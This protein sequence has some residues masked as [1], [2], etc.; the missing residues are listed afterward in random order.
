MRTRGPPATTGAEPGRGLVVAVRRLR[1]REAVALTALG[2]GSA[3]VAACEEGTMAKEDGQAKE[4]PAM[5]AILKKA[6]KR[7]LGG[8]LPGFV[9]MIIQVRAVPPCNMSAWLSGC[10]STLRGPDDVA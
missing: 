10:M 7:A 6:G 8:G 1:L 4:K 3:V 2:A 9:A 5:S